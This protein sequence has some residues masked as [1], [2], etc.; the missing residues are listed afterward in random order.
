MILLDFDGRTIRDTDDP[1]EH[2]IPAVQLPRRRC[3]V[4]STVRD[5]SDFP[6]EAGGVLGRGRTCTSCRTVPRDR[7]PRIARTSH[8]F[9][10]DFADLI[11]D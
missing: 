3:P 8:R 10:S 6:R 7:T 5:L 4:C 11:A 2:G 9:R 1:A